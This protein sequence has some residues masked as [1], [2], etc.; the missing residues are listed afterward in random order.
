MLKMR[1]E[2][3]DETKHRRILVVD[4][5]DNCRNV[6]SSM[7]SLMG[8]EAVVAGSADEALNQFLGNGFDIVLTDMNMP[9]TDGLTLARRIKDKS[10]ETPVILVTGEERESTLRM[11][12]DSSVDLA[13][14]KPLILKELQETVQRVLNT[15]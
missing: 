9:G 2:G 11:I 7:I 3:S 15:A 12:E 14:F 5:D 10:P 8:F 6:F 1:S 4:D 13:L